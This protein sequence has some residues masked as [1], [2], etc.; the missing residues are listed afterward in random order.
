[1]KVIIYCQHV[2][3]LGHFYRTLEIAMAMDNFDVILV[4]GGGSVEAKF[5]E[6]VRH[7]TLPG[8]MMDD[9]FTELYSV[10]PKKEVED[11]KQERKRQLLD[12]VK[13]EDPDYFLVELYPFGRRAFRFELTPVLDYITTLKNN[14]C[15]VLCS[16]RDILVGKKDRSKYETR[17]TEAL[18]KWFDAVLV[19]SDPELIKLDTTFHSLDKINIPLVYTGFVT[20]V[21]DVKK[22]AKIKKD[23]QLN[24][25][26]R[27]IVAS[28][29]GGNVGASLLRALVD[30]YE[31]LSSREELLLYIFTGPYMNKEDILYLNS[32]S[33]SGIK[34]EKFTHDF[35]SLLGAADLSISMAG[36]N[37]CMNIV[38]ADVPALVWPFDQ[39]LEQRDRAEKIGQFMPM[40]ILEDKDLC[41][42]RFSKLIEKTLCTQNMKS[43]KGLNINGAFNTTQ[44]IGSN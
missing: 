16:L 21:P 37:T 28:V 19:H 6:H 24:R 31:F 12:L 29:G 17:V 5:P 43:H 36:Y 34:V 15:R 11:V 44:W 7:V 9:N 4:T 10:D 18:N 40:T 41:A 3:G 26:K 22:V 32:F 30:T 20:P 25:K 2:L 14:H 27:L 39:N 23:L 33:G 13:E 38:A 42:S 1:V 8:L 35:V